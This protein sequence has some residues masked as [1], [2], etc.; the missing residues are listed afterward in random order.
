MKPF[1]FEVPCMCCG[2]KVL[3]VRQA[4]KTLCVDC[5]PC[6]NKNKRKG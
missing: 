6:L 5:T 3:R 4:S 2:R 1:F